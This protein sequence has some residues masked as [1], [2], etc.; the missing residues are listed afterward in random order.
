MK[1]QVGGLSEGVHEYHFEAEGS[2]LGLGTE[3]P[4]EVS[5]DTTLEKTGNQF[6]LEARIRTLGAFVCD[7]CI[8]EFSIPLSTS[9][10]MCYLWNGANSERLDPA[11]VQVIPAGLNVID[12]SEDVR[13]TIL[14]AVP[15]KLLCRDECKGLCPH[16]GKNHNNE[17]CGCTDSIEDSRWEKLRTL[18][19]HNIS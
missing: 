15:L 9:Y 3:F 14:L 2:E 4:H 16:C 7:R 18:Q 13:Q 1:I 5:I 11:E 8:T 12:M 10:R 19:K 17:L 6:F